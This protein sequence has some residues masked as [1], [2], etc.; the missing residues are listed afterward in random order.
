MFRRVITI[1][2]TGFVLLALVISRVTP[3]SA[4]GGAYIAF[5][6]LSGQLIVSSADGAYRWIVTNPGEMLVTPLGFNWSPD[7]RLLF[8]GVN[9]NG[10]ASLRFAD[11]ASQSAYEAA[12]ISGGSLSG[13]GWTPD[14]RGIVFSDGSSIRFLG[15]DS[16]LME[17]ISGQ[18]GASLFSPFADSRP[19]LPA[20]RSLSPD[21]RYVFFQQGD[22]RYAV[23][24]LDGSSAFPLPG[25]NELNARQSGLWASASPLVAYWGYEGGSSFLSATNA[26]SGQTVTLNSGRS[27][28][29]NPILWRPGT[30]QLVYRDANGLVRSADLACLASTCSASPLDAGLEMLPASASEITTDG[31][32]LYYV[33]GTSVMALPLSCIDAG[34]CVG[35]A[36][37][38][39]A[40]AAP[41]TMLSVGGT[42]LAFTGFSANP[43][44]VNDRQVQLVQLNGCQS[45]GGCQVL[46]TGFG[47]A[48]LVSRD[49]LA[50][51]VDVP[52]T[53]MQAISLTSGAASY[54][55][56]SMSGAG[57]PTAR[58]N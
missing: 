51:A 31:A 32:S 47:L 28:P 56:D 38:I 25:T 41:G 54:L 23:T 53:G 22:G 4:Q 16:A 48:G 37:Q 5:V 24:A 26:T 17:L 7:G 3:A 12:Q 21:G 18:A 6:N 58:W 36:V 33:D 42:T 49:G 30:S 2:L 15:T 55:S 39:A 46:S 11:P 50:L 57:L 34:A 8:F 52:G 20:A 19:N 44:D 10:A 45:S 13:G 1:F 40:N 27:A 35:S 29:V 9:L 14:S 43:N